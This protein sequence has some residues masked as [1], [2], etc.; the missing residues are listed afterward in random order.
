M[1]DRLAGVGIGHSA[2]EHQGWIKHNLV[3]I[4]VR[5]NSHPVPAHESGRFDIQLVNTGWRIFP[6]SPPLG[7]ATPFE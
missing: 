3:F 5:R 6:N 2:L 4:A 1:W 7:V